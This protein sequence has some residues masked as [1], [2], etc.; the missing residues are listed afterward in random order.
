M[1]YE[2]LSCLVDEMNEHFK[3]RLKVNEQK[4]ILSAIV[5][6]DGTIAIQGE[7]KIVIT[8]V[9]IEKETAKS[10]SQKGGATFPNTNPIVNINLLV[11]FSAYFNQ[12]NYPE[13]LRYL[14]F[15]IGY[16]VNKPTFNHSNTPGLDNKID[17]LT[18]EIVDMNP[19]AISNLWSSLGAKYMPS[20]IYKMRMLTFDDSFVREFRPSISDVSDNKSLKKE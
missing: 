17:K 19:D 10:I 11:L 8:L 6:Q 4:V 3:S 18:F 13:A 14:S 9:N 15:I 2:S 1:I 16:F 7:N 20:V 5:N 12:G